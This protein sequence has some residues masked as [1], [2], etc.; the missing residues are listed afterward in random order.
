[1]EK[2]Y[3]DHVGPGGRETIEVEVPETPVEET[4]KKTTRRKKTEDN[5]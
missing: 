4:P 3:V 1:M 2:I 5:G